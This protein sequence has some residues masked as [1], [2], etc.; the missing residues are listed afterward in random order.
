MIILRAISFCIFFIGGAVL[1]VA[2]VARSLIGQAQ[3]LH[4]GLHGDW[5][6]G[7]RKQLEIFGDKSPSTRAATA[8]GGRRLGLNH[9]YTDREECGDG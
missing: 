1:D 3:R 9:E 8:S 2:V 5:K 6:C 7:W 4:V